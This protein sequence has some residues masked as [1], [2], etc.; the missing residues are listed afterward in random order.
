MQT[1]IER[2]LKNYSN[3]RRSWEAWCFM[4]NFNLINK[5][6][7]TAQYISTNP[8]LFQLRYVVMKDFYI[9]LYK[10][11]KKSKNNK[12]NIFLLLENY[13]P[14]SVTKKKQVEYCLNKLEEQQKTIKKLCEIRDKYYAHLD[15]DYHDYLSTGIPLADILNCFYIIER[16]IITLTSTNKLREYL[17]EIPSRDEL[18]L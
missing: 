6:F 10:I 8:L 3:A 7:D 11:L 16:S 1:Q 18:N 5:S 12:D 13:V 15:D 14:T 17:D 2:L 9:E 4:V